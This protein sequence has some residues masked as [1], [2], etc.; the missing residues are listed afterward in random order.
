MA[1]VNQPSARA[2]TTHRYNTSAAG[3]ARNAKYEATPKAR[4]RTA[5][6]EATPKARARKFLWEQT[7][8]MVQRA[9]K[10]N[11]EFRPFHPRGEGWFGG[12][13]VATFDVFFKEALLPGTG[14]LFDIRDRY[15]SQIRAER[16]A[17]LLSPMTFAQL[18]AR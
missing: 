17:G 2:A 1:P 15:G 3:R 4:A 18:G 14:E 16:A 6:Y 9:P 11:L 12:D 7:V 10:S 8:R 5:R 13:A